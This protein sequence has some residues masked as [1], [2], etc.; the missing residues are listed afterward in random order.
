[1]A[2]LALFLV[3]V[4]SALVVTLYSVAAPV[5]LL[6]TTAVSPIIVLTLVFLYFERRRRPWSFAGSAA[7]G[8]V[9]VALRLIVNS[10]SDLEVGGGL[11]LW[12]TVTYVTLGALVI[13]TSGW[14]FLSLRRIDRPGLRGLPRSPA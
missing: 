5:R 7:L 9:G 14:A 13:A 4:I 8:A 6:A 2:M 11:P 12:V 10:Q 3:T 1:M